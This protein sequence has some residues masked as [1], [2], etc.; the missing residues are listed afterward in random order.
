MEGMGGIASHMRE[1][2][3][4]FSDSGKKTGAQIIFAKKPEELI[5]RV[6]A[7]LNQKGKEG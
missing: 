7:L 2:K 3:K 4:W 5:G 1:L 6:W